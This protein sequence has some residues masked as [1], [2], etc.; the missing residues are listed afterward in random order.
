MKY[1]CLPDGK[2]KFVGILMYI[3]LLCKLN[4]QKFKLLSDIEK[5]FCS[6]FNNYLFMTKLIIRNLITKTHSRIRSEIEQEQYGFVQGTGTYCFIDYTKIF[7]RIRHKE[8]LEKCNL[9]R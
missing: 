8:L 7:D 3:L 6:L 5:I 1:I 4:V 9:H 2:K